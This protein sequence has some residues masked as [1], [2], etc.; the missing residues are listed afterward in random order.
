MS[1]RA[2][3]QKR[4]RIAVIYCGGLAGTRRRGGTV[5]RSDRHVGIWLQ[6]FPEIQFIAD[7]EPVFIFDGPATDITPTHWQATA[8]A[9]HRRMNRFDGFIVVQ[10]VATIPY[11]AAALS[12]MLQSLP[13]PLVLTGAVDVTADEGMNIGI[14][15]NLLNAL[16]VATLGIPG[17]SVLFGAR[18]IAGT[19]VVPSMPG[20]V[21]LFGSYDGATLG[22]VNFG[23][24]LQ[25]TKRH[26]VR[27]DHQFAPDIDANV[28]VIE[29]HPGLS[30]LQLRRTVAEGAHGV[31]IRE[32][33]AAPIPGSVLEA[34]ARS[35]PGVP[36]L[37]HRPTPGVRA[38][39]PIVDVSGMSHITAIVKLMWTLGQT[40]DLRRVHALIRDNLAGEYGN[41]R[42]PQL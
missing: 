27:S 20:A 6:S 5:F 18:L 12:F 13:R 21:N 33:P 22:E 3:A 8:S 38:P 23:I 2:T 9:V 26:Q 14:R 30:A 42:T 41:G 39:R 31:V 36:L 37:L 7:V 1:P 4:P 10:G 40:T 28:D 34:M 15:A 25:K 32:L 11:T 24:F 17:V 35:K 29:Y 16:Q 19:Q